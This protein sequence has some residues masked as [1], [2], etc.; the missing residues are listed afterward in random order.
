MDDSASAPSPVPFQPDPSQ[1]VPNPAQPIDWLVVK[2]CANGGLCVDTVPSALYD[3]QVHGALEEAKTLGEFWL[4]LPDQERDKLSDFFFAA[5]SEARSEDVDEDELPDDWQDRVFDDC[6]SPAYWAQ[7]RT[8]FS[9]EQVPGFCDGDYPQW[10]Q[11]AL[12]EVLPEDVL[13]QFATTMHS[14]HNGPFWFIPH[15][16]DTALI[17]VLR[18]RGFH[19]E[20]TPFLR[21]W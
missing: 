20:E 4:M 13:S 11:Q 5:L 12:D 14:V 3:E 10:R 19:V 6:D 9:P 2:Y 15:E 16:S 8:P 18:L 7:D 17:N 21:G 1:L